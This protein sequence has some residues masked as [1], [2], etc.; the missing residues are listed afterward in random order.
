MRLKDAAVVR[1]IRIKSPPHDEIEAWK[2]E[3]NQW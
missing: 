2:L 3:T 1:V